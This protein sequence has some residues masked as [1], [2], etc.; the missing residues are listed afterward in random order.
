MIDYKINECK[1]QGSNLSNKYDL[2][3]MDSEEAQNE[4][5][6]LWSL[7][8]LTRAIDTLIITLSDPSHPIASLL[9]KCANEDYVDFF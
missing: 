7:I 6:G 8:P 3:A 9:K 2:V 1:N 5:V 4:F